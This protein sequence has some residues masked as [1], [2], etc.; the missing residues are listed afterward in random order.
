MKSTFWKAIA[1][2]AL[3][4]ALLFSATALGEARYPT[5]GGT[6]TDDANVLSQSVA[7][8]IA[9][10]AE[11]LESSADIKLHVAIVQFLDGEAA[12]TYADTL[13]TR[14]ELGE[15]DLLLLGAA[16]EDT[17]AVA[18][19]S[20]V[21]AK[22]SDASLKNLLYGSGFSDAFKTQQYDQAF[23]SLFV[24]LND[25]VA[26]QTGKTIALD[27][28]FQAYQSGTQSASGQ[29]TLQNT[30]NAVVDTSSQLWAN[31]IDSI[32]NSV[33]NYQDYHQQRDDSGSGLTPGGWIVLAVIVLIIF[34]QSAPGRR[35][36]R[37]GCGCSPI[38]WVLGGLGL[39]AL[40]NRSRGED[41]HRGPGG[42]GRP[43]RW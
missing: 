16:A 41:Y 7:A 40:W 26:K 1:T 33:Q 15:N 10:Y 38:G 31:T 13:F 3:A 43:R 37:S 6:V 35:A 14:W 17:F 36:R 34:G 9:A 32:S 12:Q 23:G 39:G 30:L 5:L 21:K 29:N 27:Q 19:G 25:L 4:L 28:L 8:D 20:G 22:L 11:K 2:V 42:F 24:A 18:T